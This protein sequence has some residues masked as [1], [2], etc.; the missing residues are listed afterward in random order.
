MDAAP[1]MDQLMQGF[2][3]IQRKQQKS[4][5]FRR[6]T[7]LGKWKVLDDKTQQLMN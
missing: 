7:S 5:N 3:L 2:T 6:F 1:H 4:P